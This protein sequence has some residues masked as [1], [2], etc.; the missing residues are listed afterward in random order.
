MGG[1]VWVATM[2]AP[3]GVWVWGV[4]RVEHNPTPSDGILVRGVQVRQTLD[5]PRGTCS[6]GQ[7]PFGWVVCTAARAVH[8]YGG[9]VGAWVWVASMEAPQGGWVYR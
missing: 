9:L 1:W 3:L 7:A 6:C 2:E 8:G 5:K 4:Q